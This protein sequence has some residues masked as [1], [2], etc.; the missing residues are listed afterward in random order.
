MNGSVVETQLSEE[1]V[2]ALSAAV[3]E[4]L[5]VCKRLEKAVNEVRKAA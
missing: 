3:A 5:S 2:E 1:D 4:L